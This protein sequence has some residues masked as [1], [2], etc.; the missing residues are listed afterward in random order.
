MEAVFIENSLKHRDFPIV[1]TNCR[2]SIA[3]KNEIIDNTIDF[4]QTAVSV[5]P[6]YGVIP[7]LVIAGRVKQ[8]RKDIG[9]ERTRYGNSPPFLSSGKPKASTQVLA[10]VAIPKAME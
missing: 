5:V 6:D 8:S 2:K 4:L 1:F 9:M 10:A 3:M 7:W